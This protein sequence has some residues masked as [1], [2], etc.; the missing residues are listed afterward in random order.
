MPRAAG[1]DSTGLSLDLPCTEDPGAGPFAESP[2][3]VEQAKAMCRGC[4]ARL[5][6][7]AGALERREPWGV[8]GGE[9]LM[10]GAI[11]P[12]KR[13]RGRPRKDVV[14]IGLVTPT[15]RAGSL[16]C[17]PPGDDV[18]AVPRV[19][20][21]DE[22]HQRGE[23][24]LVIVLGRIRPGL[25]GHV[26][27][28]AGRRVPC[29]ARVNGDDEGLRPRTHVQ[30]VRG[31]WAVALAVLIP[32]DV[33]PLGVLLGRTLD[34]DR[35][36]GLER[37]VEKLGHRL[38]DFLAAGS[39]CPAQ[40]LDVP[41]IKNEPRPDETR[42][43]A[44]AAKSPPS[45]PNKLSESPPPVLGPSRCH[46]RSGSTPRSTRDLSGSTHVH[47]A[48]GRTARLGVM[49][50][51]LCSAFAL[52]SAPAIR[53]GTT[54]VPEPESAPPRRRSRPAPRPGCPLEPDLDLA[55]QRPRRSEPAGHFQKVVEAY[56]RL[57]ESALAVQR[58]REAPQRLGRRRIGV[59]RRLGGPRAHPQNAQATTAPPRRAPAT[60][61]GPRAP[62]RSGGDGP[63]TGPRADDQ[64]SCARVPAASPEHPSPIPGRRGG[65][66]PEQ[67]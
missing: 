15:G 36:A 7:L 13:P 44:P 49:N 42:E 3:D 20:A 5:A 28:A 34:G 35:R 51:D 17:R 56:A 66:R 11:V 43:R 39:P 2:Q 37:R 67:G 58:D 52:K 1:Q 45:P 31:N 25:V 12:R 24:L 8:W 53:Y 22:R 6:C 40:V 14:P 23:L 38:A 63:P 55:A 4:R 62:D 30:I 61:S 47:Q 16:G 26:A 64:G 46:R 54:Q 19:D 48:A 29:S 60:R 18:Q 41:L 9:L 65:V 33:C 57:L 21:R 10:G 50:P 59:G 32:W 27:G